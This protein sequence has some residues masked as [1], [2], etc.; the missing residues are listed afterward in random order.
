MISDNTQASQRYRELVLAWA[1][2]DQNCPPA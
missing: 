2:G 1:S